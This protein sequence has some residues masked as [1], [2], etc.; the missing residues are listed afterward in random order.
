MAATVRV[1]CI[2]MHALSISP[3]DA[4]SY[5]PALQ[6]Q[7]AQ[8]QRLHYFGVLVEINNQSHQIATG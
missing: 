4:D 3:L 2:P 5:Y 1:V 8:A 6:S 7:V